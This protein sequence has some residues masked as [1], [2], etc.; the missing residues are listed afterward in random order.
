MSK[1]EK[2]P[3]ILKSE[4][5]AWKS[6]KGERLLKLYQEKSARQIKGED[7]SGIEK[8]IT[9]M[10]KNISQRQARLEKNLSHLYERMYKSGASSGAKKARQERTHRLCNIGGLVEKAGLGEM[11]QD[12]LFGM[13]LQQADYLKGNPG[14]ISRWKERGQAEL[15]GALRAREE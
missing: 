1:N 4:F 5:E 15:A 3:E 8:K 14:I 9:D 13:L 7:T 11:E 10:E 12:V 6:K 2:T